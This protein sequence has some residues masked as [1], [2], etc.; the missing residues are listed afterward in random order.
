[1]RMLRTIKGVT[2]R[3]KEKSG[4]K[5][6]ARSEQHIYIVMFYPNCNFTQHH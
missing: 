4:H 5:K 6:G 2:L 3:D 1:M